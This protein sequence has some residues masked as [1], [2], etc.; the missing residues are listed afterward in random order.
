M[1][2]ALQA[3]LFDECAV[4]GLGSLGALRRTE[5]SRGAWIDVLPGC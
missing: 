5:L 3:S 2:P 1:T 4:L